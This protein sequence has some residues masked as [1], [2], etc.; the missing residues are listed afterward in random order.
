MS[1]DETLGE[2]QAGAEVSTAPRRPYWA[3][4]LVLLAVVIAVLAAAF[5]LDRQLR[6]RVGIEATATTPA[7]AQA[8]TSPTAAPSPTAP[9]A[10][11][12]TAQAAAVPTVV[13][14]PTGLPVASSPLEREIEQAYLKYWDIRSEALYNLD[15][16]RLPEVMAGAELEREQQQVSELKAQ[17][18]A[19]KTDVEHR[20]AFVRVGEAN[21][22]LYDEY[23]NRSYLI[24]AQ[25]KQ[26]IRTP[27]PG[28][29]AKVS[30]RLQKI[31]GVWKVV[32][33]QRFD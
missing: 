32:D 15:P 8:S 2:T 21:A 31:D 9:A 22:E 19:V 23:V 10:A 1:P 16:R 25:T 26:A 28:G 3:V 20:I 12:L 30:Y 7:L 13:A 14:S 27:G 6:P 24:D 33:G 29:T 18:R 5:L 4:G 17:G 11:T